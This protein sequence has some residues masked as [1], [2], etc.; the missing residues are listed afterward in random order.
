VFAST[1]DIYTADMDAD[2]GKVISQPKPLP[3]P[4]AG[5]NVLPRW[6]PDSR[7]ILYHWVQWQ[8]PENFIYSTETGTE[9][10]IGPDIFAAAPCWSVNGI[11][12]QGESGPSSAVPSYEGLK[13]VNGFISLDPQSGQSISFSGAVDSPVSCAADLIAYFT[14]SGIRVRNLKTNLEMEVH[15]FETRTVRTQPLISHNGRF[16]A[17]GLFSADA[18]SSGLV[19]GSSSGGPV[20]KLVKIKSPVEFQ[21]SFGIAWSP[22]DKYVYFLKRSD[23]ASPY[24]LWRVPAGGGTEESASLKFDNLRDIDISPDGKRIAF[25]VGAIVQPEIWAMENFMAADSV[26]P[27]FARS[28]KN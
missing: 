10:R 11:L 13:R 28:G 4:R 24:E 19:V 2:T 23:I 25:S 27:V 6:S 15:H 5:F 20:R 21:H 8:P 18:D 9:Q 3:L 16:V 12:I 7:R 17:F 14:A 26:R 1:S 22:D